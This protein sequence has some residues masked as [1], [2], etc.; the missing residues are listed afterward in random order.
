M[1]VVY[2]LDTEAAA[3][4]KQLGVT[5]RRAATPGTHPAI[6]AMIRELILERVAG[7]APR[8]LGGRGPLPP[9]CPADCCLPTNPARPAPRA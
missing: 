5:M 2:D 1:E 3:L 8:A 7:A 6:V 9:D 4:A